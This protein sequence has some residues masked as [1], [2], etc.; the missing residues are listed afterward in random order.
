MCSSG[1]TASSS[2][3][4]LQWTIICLHDFFFSSMAVQLRIHFWDKIV[5]LKSF[6]FLEMAMYK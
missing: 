4:S 3:Q 5:F 2:I 6:F 1:I